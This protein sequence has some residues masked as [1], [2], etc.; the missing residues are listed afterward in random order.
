M[1][2]HDGDLMCHVHRQLSFLCLIRV[3][4]LFLFAPAIFYPL[5]LYYLP[6]KLSASVSAACLFKM[7]HVLSLSHVLEDVLL[8][9]LLMTDDSFDATQEFRQSN[10]PI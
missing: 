6:L 2:S 5:P 4:V 9:F 3:L 7:S 1:I 10:Q 8:L